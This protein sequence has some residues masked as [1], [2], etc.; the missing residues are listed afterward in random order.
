MDKDQK[1]EYDE[2]QHHDADT[3]ADTNSGGAAEEPDVTNP[4]KTD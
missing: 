3:E 2:L 4:Q 1:P